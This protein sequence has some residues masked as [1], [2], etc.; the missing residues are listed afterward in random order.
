MT[1]AEFCALSD[2]A[3]ARHVAKL[4]DRERIALVNAVA[5]HHDPAAGENDPFR[6]R[7]NQQF[8]EWAAKRAPQ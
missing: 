8:R 4:S 7:L 3:K 1:A 2:S 5:A 6:L